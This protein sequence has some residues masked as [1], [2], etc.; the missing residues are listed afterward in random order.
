M[1]FAI[2]GAGFAGLSVAWF[3]LHYTQGS[4]TIDIYDPEPIGK[5]ASGLSS[6]LLH[7]YA[8]KRAKRIWRADRCMKETHRLI[9][10]SSQALGA[11]LILSKGILRPA[12]TEEQVADFQACTQ[13]NAD[14]AWWDKKRCEEAVKGLYLPENG[15]G[16]FIK[17]GLTLDSVAYLQGLWQA[18]ALLGTQLH[19]QPMIHPSDLA[20]YDRILIAMGPLTKHFPLL[21]D[22][23]LNAVKGQVLDLE[24]PRELS[25]PPYSLVG[26][27]YLVMDREQ[28]ICTVGATY[29]HT[30]SSPKPDETIASQEIL[31]EIFRYFPALKEARIV[32][33]R[34]GFRATTPNHLPVVGKI[35]DK[36]YFFTGL[37]SKGLFFHGWVGKR[38]A[39]TLLTKDSSH[40]PKEL[41]YTL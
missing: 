8:G 12:L 16:L 24:W 1:R 39:R 30:F 40:L 17:E 34:A 11:P 9:T 35:S 31:P 32:N 29:E 25:P 2:L 27:K 3:L 36:F 28:K 5:G 20:P 22:L 15:G 37:G 10:A 14:T 7:P 41:I 19:T 4:A 38:V 33:C 6:G 13:E 23:P 21:K 26:K 18:C